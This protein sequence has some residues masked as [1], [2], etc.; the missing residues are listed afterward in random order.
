MTVFELALK[1]EESGFQWKQWPNSVK[2]KSAIAP[3][4]P[5]HDKLWYSTTALPLKQYLLALL[6]A[7]A[8]LL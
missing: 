3:Y 8:A 5:G 6:N 4:A 1:L 2:H 7:E